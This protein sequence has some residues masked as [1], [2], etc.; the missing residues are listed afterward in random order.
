MRKHIAVVMAVIMALSI[1]GCGSSKSLFPENTGE[2][3]ETK[4]ADSGSMKVGYLLSSD[5]DAPDTVA[6]VQGIR[7]MQE[8]TGIKDDQ[9]II[10]ESVKKSDCDKYATELAEKG[11]SF[12]FSENPEF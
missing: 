2:Q 1:C 6:R 4:T 3:Q 7:K 8:Q 5:G 10:K 9:I 11:W 12:I